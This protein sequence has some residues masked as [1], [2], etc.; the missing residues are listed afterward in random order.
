MTAG[1]VAGLKPYPAYKPS[2]VERLGEVPEHWEVRR[3]KYVVTLVMGQSPPGETCSDKPIGLPFLQGCAEWL[4]RFRVGRVGRKGK[5]H[6]RGCS[7]RHSRKRTT[8]RHSRESMSSRKQGRESI[9]FPRSRC[10]NPLVQGTHGVCSQGLDSRFR[11]NDEAR[12]S[13]G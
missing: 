9:H 6:L 10:T 5:Q 7:P 4:F 8:L 11:G 12:L 13:R 1:T 3:L 2:G